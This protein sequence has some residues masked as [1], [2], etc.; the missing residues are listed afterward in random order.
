MVHEIQVEVTMVN[1]EGSKR[2]KKKTDA[3]KDDPPGTPKKVIEP[4]PT[5]KEKED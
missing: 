2:A 1:K 3:S 5:E 4:S